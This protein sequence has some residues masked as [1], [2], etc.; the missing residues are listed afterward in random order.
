MCIR[1][2][3]TPVGTVL[4]ATY[5]TIGRYY[6][7][8]TVGHFYYRLIIGHFHCRLTIGHFYCRLRPAWSAVRGSLQKT[9]LS[10][11]SRYSRISGELCTADLSTAAQTYSPYILSHRASLSH[12]S[13]GDRDSARHLPGLRAHLEPVS[14]GGR[15]PDAAGEGPPR[16]GQYLVAKVL[17]HG[18]VAVAGI[19]ALRPS[20]SGADRTV[21]IRRGGSA[22]SARPPDQGAE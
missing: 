3:V 17:R 1:P 5:L 6:C 4:S 2:P 22:G 16:H 13:S 11:S 10:R 18:D 9:E 20:A 19:P 14:L 8:L 21:Q 7:R 12:S 15:R